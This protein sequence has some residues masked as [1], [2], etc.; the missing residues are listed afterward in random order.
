[1]TIEAAEALA[2][3]PSKSVSERVEELLSRLT[4]EEKIGQMSQVQGG[5]GWIPDHLADGIRQGHVG[6]V[7]NEVDL[8]TVNEL[9][10]QTQPGHL[11]K[12]HGERLNGEQRSIARAALI[13]AKLHEN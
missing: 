11:Q 3:V 5:G 9:F 6:S 4:L 10:I 7:I 12:L 1:M 2:A 13:R 8:D